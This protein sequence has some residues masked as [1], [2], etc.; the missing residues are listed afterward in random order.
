MKKVA[1]L[2]VEF[3]VEERSLL[4]LGYK[5][6]IGKRRSAWRI[7]SSYEQQEEASG[8]EENIRRIKEYR[9]RVEDELTEI[10][11][12]IISIIDKHLIP[13]SSTVEPNIFYY[14]M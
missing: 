6:V 8:N 7:I 12:D 10:S 5:T 1:K 4:F 2:D 11:N 9:H 14:K 13:S 3:T